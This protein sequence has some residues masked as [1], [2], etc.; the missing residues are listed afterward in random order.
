M[1]WPGCR[2]IGLLAARPA[3]TAPIASSEYGEL[4]RP[5][6]CCECHGPGLAER[7]RV[8]EARQGGGRSR[9][10]REGTYWVVKLNVHWCVDQCGDGFVSAERP[11]WCLGQRV[12]THVSTTSRYGL[13][14]GA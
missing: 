8:G 12:S 5:G 11:E 3:E 4:M 9:E 2:R 6:S 10:T 13:V 1:W 7:A 14:C